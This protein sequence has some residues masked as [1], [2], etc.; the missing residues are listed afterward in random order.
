MKITAR[1]PESLTNTPF[2][3]CPGC[4]H[5]IINRLVAE[6]IDE[7]GIRKKTI[8][9]GSVGC[10]VMIYKFFSLDCIIPPHGRA[11]AVAGGSKDVL[12][13]RI[14][15][16]YQGDGDI[17]IGL[18]E[19]IDAANRGENITVVFVNNAI[20]GMT[21]GQMAI[22][23]VPGQKTTT[24]PLGKDATTNGYPLRVCELLNTLEA[25][26]YL[27]RVAVNSPKRVLQ[28]KKALKKA[29]EIQLA[30]KGFSLVEVLSACPIGWGLTP[31]ESLGWIDKTMVPVF[32]LGEFKT[33]K[34]D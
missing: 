10:S 19:L 28:A 31:Q 32:P 11:A 7:L 3:Y 30:G 16:S 29:F 21:G 34:E 20:Y 13:D 1:K 22:T 23:S 25:P 14:V 4:H 2:T 26:M 24:S 6:V 12:P 18:L 15:F 33:P 27:A 17:T 9:V 5:G 8:L